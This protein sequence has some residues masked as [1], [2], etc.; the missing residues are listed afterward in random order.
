MPA[1]IDVKTG[2]TYIVSV[3][4][5]SYFPYTSNAML[6]PPVNGYLSSVYSHLNVTPGSYPGSFV[7]TNYFRDV[8]FEV[9]P[10]PG[11]LIIKGLPAVN[12]TLQASIINDDAAN[13][14]IAYQWEISTDESTWTPISGATNKAYLPSGGD[15]SKFIRTRTTFSSLYDSSQKTIYSASSVRIDDLTLATSVFTS[16]TP[17]VLDQND[18]VG[19]ELGMKFQ[20]S[21][22]GKIWGIRYYRALNEDSIHLGKLW[23][24]GGTLLGSQNFR[25]ETG[26]GWQQE[27]FT[28]P[29]SI[30]AGTTYVASVNVSSRY[31]YTSGGLSTPITNGQLTGTGAAF[32]PSPESFPTTAWNS[33]YFVDVLFIPD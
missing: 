30:S 5:I 28:T 7:A 11:E 18:N 32:N 27:F 19:Y 4:T 13:G 1:P 9:L 8:V 29:I 26:P 2:R 16:Q 17:A 6:S 20:S 24:A 15:L 3:N 31:V 21:V 25:A 10:D 12:Q 33:N 23:T 22:P 14:A